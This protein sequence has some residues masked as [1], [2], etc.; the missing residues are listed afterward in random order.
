MVGR[1]AAADQFALSIT[2]GGVTSGNAATT[3]G[4]T[5]GSADRRLVDGRPDRRVGR[6][7]LS[8]PR[9]GG[10]RDARELH[11]LGIVRDT[12]NGNAAVT[13]TPRHAGSTTDYSLVFPSAS[14]SG[15]SVVACTFIDTP[16]GAADDHPHQVTG[17]ARVA[18]G[19]Q[20]TVAI[21]TGGPSGPVVSSTAPPPR[22]VPGR[23]STPG[24]GTTG[25][26]VGAAATTYYLT[27]SASGTTDLAGYLATISC[28]EAPGSSP[29][30][31]AA[32]RSADRWRSPRSTAPGSTA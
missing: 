8:G 29:V 22:R 20:F 3:S 25:S 21:R 10:E 9:V 16:A 5:T 32:S 24:T 2:G 6:H 14:G 23:P 12:G 27:E 17:T 19:D 1:Y 31:R 11:A 28:T 18:A 13:L 4:A 15:S 30:C 26:Y 7:D